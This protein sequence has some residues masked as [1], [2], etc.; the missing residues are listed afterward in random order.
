MV[1]QHI[2]FPKPEVCSEEAMY[3]RRSGA[4]NY[5]FASDAITVH[6]GGRID[7]NT[8]F[9]S[10]SMG[11]W[12]KYTYAKKVSLTVSFSGTFLLTLIKE[13]RVIENTVKTVLHE[14]IISSDNRT[15]IT[16][17]FNATDANGVYYFCLAALRNDSKIY[18]GY[19]SIDCEDEKAISNVKLGIA[20]CHYK[21][22]KYI[23]H[24]MN[25][26]A[27][28]IEAHSDFADKIEVFIADNGQTLTS[29]DAPY[30]FVNIFKNKN[31]GGAGGFGRCMYEIQ[32]A[33]KNGAGITHILLMDDDL[34]FDAETVFRTWAFIS[35]LKP[36]YKKYFISGAMCRSD[37]KNIQHENGALWND[38]NIISLKRLNLNDFSA[39]LFN[40]CYEETPDFAAWWYCAI[41]VEIT[42]N[43]FPMPIF[44]REDDVEYSLRNAEGVISMNGLCV[45][46]EPFENKF[47]PFVCYY[48]MRN[49]HI[50]NAIHSDC[51]GRSL[52]PG[53]KLKS[54]KQILLQ[55]TLN[56]ITREV[57]CLRY[58][59]A[60]LYLDAAFD[61]LRG[62]D[63]LK[64]TDTVEQHK[65]ISAS[66]YKLVDAD[67]I[68]EMPFMY[69]YYLDSI[70]KPPYTGIKKFL[71]KHSDNGYRVKPTKDVW[72]PIAI[73]K[74][75]PEMFAHAK[76]AYH[77]DQCTH[78]GFVT[79]RSKS[80]YERIKKRYRQL[81]RLAN[82]K[83]KKVAAEYKNRSGEIF[84][85]D[86]WKKYLGV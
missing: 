50:T 47:V 58:K 14:N 77:Y 20:I 22:E 69:G 57:A 40:D 30:P 71:W 84:S 56:E 3:F 9:N 16:V 38:G 64:N 44:Y 25:V 19:Y 34:T 8:Y 43:N 59:I 1:V 62:I 10:F 68:K 67:K 41:P 15:E 36:E 66:G 78:R 75:R 24:N 54:G 39:C 17:P 2:S 35:V 37:Y 12:N 4:V 28:Y 21:K 27:R 31:L 55:S 49:A 48:H 42:Y 51:R 73:E 86:F 81:V 63:W 13:D 33:N 61:F 65:K 18:G 79:E 85:E 7:F 29:K 83:Y 11:K 74:V 60:D 52:A 32:Q 72:V 23:I 70:N 82:R 45:W 80:E 46:H 76:R 5:F 26:L 6:N 53:G